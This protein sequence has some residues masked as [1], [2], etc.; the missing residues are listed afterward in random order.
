MTT[1]STRQS[2]KNNIFLKNILDNSNLVDSDL[3]NKYWFTESKKSEL[4][5]LTGAQKTSFFI[6][7][8][9]DDDGYKLNDDG[10]YVLSNTVTL[11]DNIT[12]G[13]QNSR[14]FFFDDYGNIQ[15][16]LEDCTV[17]S[18]SS[19]GH[20]SSTGGECKCFQSSGIYKDISQGGTMMFIKHALNNRTSIKQD[21]ALENSIGAKV[22]TPDLANQYVYDDKHIISPNLKW[23]LRK[24]E[25]FW[26][27]LYNPMHRSE[28]QQ[29]Y[30]SAQNSDAENMENGDW[31]ANVPIKST[32]Q[33]YCNSFIISDLEDSTKQL[34]DPT[35]NQVISSDQCLRNSFYQV[36]LTKYMNVPETLRAA[37]NTPPLPLC[38]CSGKGS[39]YARSDA[40]SESFIRYFGAPGGLSNDCGGRSTSI[41]VCNINI[42]AAHSVQTK[43]GVN[44]QN[45]CGNDVTATRLRPVI[46]LKG[47]RRMLLPQYD[48]FVD[49]GSESSDGSEVI[50][51]Y[52][53]KEGN[54]YTPVEG[55]DTSFVGAE[56]VVRYNATN[57]T[58]DKVAIEKKREVAII[59]A[60]A[61]GGG[62][63]ENGSGGG[64]FENDTPG[65]S[66]TS[67]RPDAPSPAGPN[68]EG[69]EFTNTQIVGAGLAVIA[70][71]LL[72]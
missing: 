17:S 58:N 67:D 18:D 33:K 62:G 42:D 9:Y 40:G 39:E 12:T 64:G 38:L 28:F 20:A 3:N 25:N 57:P 45:S 26:Y 44:I 41:S 51:S 34:L 66:G 49:P 46:T 72:L 22:K 69:G 13:L 4:D 54:R 36:N 5:V 53:L 32:L 7:K 31:Y 35:C 10:S 1:E 21:N 11:S 70:L 68:G 6:V 59:S 37:Y 15:L 43:G 27:L 63:F 60:D 71:Y 61:S 24:R 8:K 56:F 47:P 55:I 29:I 48:Q 30:Q 65:P 23:I 2:I 52:D 16:C 14:Y 50:V 19:I